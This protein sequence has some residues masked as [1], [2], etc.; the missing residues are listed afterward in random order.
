[1]G[2]DRQIERF[3]SGD[4]HV[5][6]ARSAAASTIRGFSEKARARKLGQ[7]VM[8]EFFELV[9]QAVLH[10]GHAVSTERMRGE[11][12]EDGDVTAW[13][14]RDGSEVLLVVWF[15]L[16]RHGNAVPM[17]ITME[18]ADYAALDRTTI[19]H[20]GLAKAHELATEFLREVDA[21]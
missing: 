20:V 10:A 16:M 12:V 3:A 4:G 18:P 14:L 15:F 6:P 1:M 5:F 2:A 9:N 21:G 17:L 7:G 8:P 19:N 13:N 11:Q